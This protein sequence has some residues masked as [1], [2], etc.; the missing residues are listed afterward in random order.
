MSSVIH[1]FGEPRCF[2]LPLICY[3]E[4]QKNT[5]GVYTFSKFPDLKMQII[6]NPLHK[7]T[8]P[9]IYVAGIRGLEFAGPI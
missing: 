7:W 9:R 5:G 6:M 2:V 8:W 4:Y 1:Y 3:A